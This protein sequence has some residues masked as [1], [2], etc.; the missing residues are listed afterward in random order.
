MGE[1]AKKSDSKLF[2]TISLASGIFE[3]NISIIKFF[4]VSSIGCMATKIGA[5]Q[6]GIN[7]TMDTEDVLINTEIDLFYK[8]S[9]TMLF[10]NC[11]SY[12]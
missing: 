5:G 7:L 6:F 9:T 2:L 10:V 1:I 11:I 3:V 8:L 4:F 12:Q